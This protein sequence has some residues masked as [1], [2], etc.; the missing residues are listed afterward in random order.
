MDHAKQSIQIEYKHMKVKQNIHTA[1]EQMPLNGPGEPRHR[2]TKFRTSFP[3][4]KF[5]NGT[6]SVN[7]KKIENK[8]NLQTTPIAPPRPTKPSEQKKMNRQDSVQPPRIHSRSRT[9]VQIKSTKLHWLSKESPT[10]NYKVAI[11]ET[12]KC[13]ADLSI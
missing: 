8:T 10:H 9:K 2:Q 13:A 6:P 4:M 7:V 11:K 5:Q 12:R 3:K 1:T